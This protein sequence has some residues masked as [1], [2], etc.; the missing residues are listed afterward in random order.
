[1]ARSAHELMQR[2][3]QS[4]RS[5]LLGREVAPYRSVRPAGRCSSR[6]SRPRRPHSAHMDMCLCH[7]SQ[8]ESWT[9]H[10]RLVEVHQPKRTAD[11]RRSCLDPRE[12]GVLVPRGARSSLSA[13]QP[14]CATLECSS[15]TYSAK[16]VARV[17]MDAHEQIT[18]IA[19]VVA[20]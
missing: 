7:T 20:V 6:R 19:V 13:H 3:M 2:C 11:T 14:T 5:D 4:T 8:C 15:I 18:T 16:C 17:H 9:A 12:R 1:M 10:G